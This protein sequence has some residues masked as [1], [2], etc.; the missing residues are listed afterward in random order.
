MGEKLAR[1]PVFL[2]AAQVRHNPVLALDDYAASLQDRFRKIGFPDYKVR[3]QSEYEIDLSNASGGAKVKARESRQHSYLN[4]TGSAC[5]VI[6]NARLFYQVT[7]YDVF[8]TFRDEFV[9][10]LELLDDVVTLDYVDAVSMRLLDAIVPD[11]DEQL[12]AYLAAPLLGIAEMLEEPTWGVTHAAS[13][14][15]IQTPDHHVVVRTLA[16]HGKVSVPPDLNIQGMQLMPPFADVDG[17]H[18]ILDTDCVFQV[19]QQF[20]V[21]AIAARLRLLKDDLRTT[22]HAAVTKHALN[23]WS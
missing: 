21:A 4:R 7:E 6:E 15:A 16:R 18:A 13:E 10:G 11:S 2:T 1:A 3:V 23:R 17:V 8:D 14:T 12:S 22:F 5:F 19:R 9:R 20:D